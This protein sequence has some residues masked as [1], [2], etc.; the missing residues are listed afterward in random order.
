MADK[1]DIYKAVGTSGL[2]RQG[3]NVEE[4]YERA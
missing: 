4:E 1:V 2:N 3:G